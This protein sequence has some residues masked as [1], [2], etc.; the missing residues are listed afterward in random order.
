M[1]TGAAQNINE[2]VCE[3]NVPISEEYLKSIDPAVYNRAM[4]EPV[5]C[6]KCGENSTKIINHFCNCAFCSNCITT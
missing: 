6:V 4:S 2:I 3:C 5:A 1:W